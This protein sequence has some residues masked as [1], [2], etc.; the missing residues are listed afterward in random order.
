MSK[1]LTRVMI[2]LATMGL[3]VPSI[4]LGSTPVVKPTVRDVALL[5]GSVLIGQVL[6]SSG[7]G[8]AETQVLLQQQGKTIVTVLP[9]TGERYISTWP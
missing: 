4:A 6:D 5:D 9:S 3:C 8:M 7:A 1:V 2:V